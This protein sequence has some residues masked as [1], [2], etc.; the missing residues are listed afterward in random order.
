MM[1]TLT[2]RHFASD[3][4]AG[5]HTQVLEAITNANVGHVPGYGNDYFTERAQIAFQ[6][7][8]G[9]DARVFFALNGTGANVVALASALRPHQAL[10]CP[11]DAHLNIGECGAFERFV[12]AKIIGVPTKNGKL[13]PE[14]ILSRMSEIGNAHHVQLAAISVSQSTEAGTVYSVAELAALGAVTRRHGLFFHVDGARLANAAATLDVDL[15]TM[16]LETGVDV[17]SFGGTKN[18]LLFGEAVVFPKRHPALEAM[19]FVFKQGMQMSS[20][21]RFVAVQFE[22]LLRDDLWLVSARHANRMAQ[23]LAEHVRNMPNVRIVYPVESNVVFAQLP[24]HAVAPL[25]QQRRFY[26]RDEAASI[27]RLMTAFDTREEDVDDFA[28]EIAHAVS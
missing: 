14:D 19:P 24:S 25:Q 21:M 9:A 7:M 4:Y 12:G 28:K 1:E 27:V 20:K 18:G 17:F 10:I 5:A 22:A 15:R 2:R 8:L 3:N 6:E 23:R 13:T 16:L 26:L 11:E